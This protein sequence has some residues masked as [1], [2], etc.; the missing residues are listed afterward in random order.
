MLTQQTF[1][2]CLF[3]LPSLIPTEYLRIIQRNSTWMFGVH[4]YLCPFGVHAIIILNQIS[5]WT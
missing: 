3:Q 4:E 1:D 5:W 2:S